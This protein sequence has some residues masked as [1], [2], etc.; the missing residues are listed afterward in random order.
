MCS[1]VNGGYVVNGYALGPTSVT[2]GVSY[3]YTLSATVNPGGNAVYGLSGQ[4]DFGDGRT[5]NCWDNGH[6]NGG[7]DNCSSSGSHVY[8]S[9]GVYTVSFSSYLFNGGAGKMCDGTFQVQVSDPAPKVGTI[10]VASNIPTSWTVSGPGGSFSNGGTSWCRDDLVG[11][12]SLSNVP[13]IT[14]YVGPNINNPSPQKLNQGGG[15][16]WDISYSP[17]YKCSAG[18]SCVAVLDN[19]GTHTSPNCN[20]SCVAAA[21]PVPSVTIVANPYNVGS[22]GSSNISWAVSDATSC[23]ASGGWAGSKDASNG[24]H[25]QVINNITANPTTFTLTCTNSNGT[26]VASTNVGIIAGC[27]VNGESKVSGAYTIVTFKCSGTFNNP[28]GV[29]SVD[30]LVVGGGG[31]GAGG[32]LTGGG[33]GGG[34]VRSGTNLAVVPSTSYPV[35]VGDG[36]PA[37]GEPD[38]TGS[39]GNSS[40]F[41]S[42]VSVGGS[43]GG[44]GGINGVSGTIGGGGGG[45]DAGPGSGGAGGAGSVHSGGGGDMNAGGGGG[46]AGGNGLNGGG[47]NVAGNGGV[48]T[49]SPIDSLYYGGGGGGASIDWNHAGTGGL[50]GGGNGGGGNFTSGGAGTAN[51]GGGGGGGRF[52]V[53]GGNGGSGIVI[54]KY[55]TPT[56]NSA[57]TSPVI[58]GPVSGYVNI[59]NTYSL[60]S[61]DP[62]S[63]Q[64]RYGIDWDNNGTVDEWSPNGG[65]VNSGTSRSAVHTWAST[66]AKTF[67]ALAEDSS[68]AQSGWT[69]FTV[70]IASAPVDGACGPA[71]K[72]YAYTDGAFVGATCSSGTAYPA[73]QFPA[74]DSSSQWICQGSNGGSDSPICVASRV[75]SGIS[76]TVTKTK[77]GYVISSDNVI[78]CGSSCSKSYPSPTTVTLQAY[79]SSS[80]WKFAGWSG[81]CNGLGSCVLN[82]NAAKTVNASFILRAFD[83]IEF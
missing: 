70:N 17:K 80:Y 63:N 18:G 57:P 11:D 60:V 43:G 13:T 49:Q 77:G 51:T 9:P 6:N 33:G 20:N 28:A 3:D 62:E 32:N 27:S 38:N 41:N 73:P 47:S 42:V 23:T 25:S 64:I 61:T 10:C 68:G 59:G 66:G 19:S 26:T 46:G 1:E 56:I 36:G 65:Y 78:N 2:T 12:W 75:G 39:N 14:G 55:L 83:Y 16:S 37:G 71:A 40:S 50:G 67:K 53:P 24:T 69:S 7:A 5:I 22:G 4:I 29:N 21:N 79:P 54:L 35:V 81:D 74:A 34:Q 45:G 15:V 72:A 82:V 30:Y 58:T 48:G 76:L 52:Q 44:N 8:Y 31:G